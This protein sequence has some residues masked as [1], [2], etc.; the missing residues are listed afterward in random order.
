MKSGKPV[1]NPF[2]FTIVE[3]MIVLAVTLIIF[4]SAVIA[5]NGRTQKAEFMQAVNDTQSS[6]QAIMNDVAT[7]YYNTQNV[8]CAVTN[9]PASLQFS[10]AAGSTTGQGDCMFLGQ[11]LLFTSGNTYYGFDVFG[12]RQDITCTSNC[13]LSTD[14]LDAQPTIPPNLPD[15]VTASSLSNELVAQ[16]AK[17][18]TGANVSATVGTNTDIV[19]FLDD[20]NATGGTSQSSNSS[21][22]GAIGVNVVPRL[23]GATLNN[24][25]TVS[26]A[27]GQAVPEVNVGLASSQYSLTQTADGTTSP[28]GDP[29]GKNPTGGVGVCFKSQSTDQSVLFTFGGTNRNTTIENQ[30]F[31]GAT[32]G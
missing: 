32:C 10:T 18:S 23:H 26:A 22:S 14:Y 5:V 8:Y 25:S 12:A 27:L 3:V 4:A 6:F 16:W 15:L 11:A 20:P 19:A 17:Y 31:S 1:V 21:G 9:T 24:Y 7:G 29:A 28:V 13:N 30:I 2:G